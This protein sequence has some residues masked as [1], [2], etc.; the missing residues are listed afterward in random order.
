MLDAL[1]ERVAD[2]LQASSERLSD[3]PSEQILQSLSRELRDAFHGIVSD[4]EG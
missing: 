3:L 2:L 1:T 4:D